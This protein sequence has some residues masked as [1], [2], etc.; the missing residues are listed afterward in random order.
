MPDL[1]KMGCPDD[2][3]TSLD[4]GIAQAVMILR[5]GDVETFE[6]CEGGPG[7]SFPEPAVRFHGGIGEGYRALGIA[8]TNGLPVSELRR[9]W[10]FDEGAI[11]GP[12]WELVF[13]KKLPAR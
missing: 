4:S 7:H 9:A 13:R 10:S 12:Y 5:G 11:V 6:S 2:E 3:L 1:T 8:L